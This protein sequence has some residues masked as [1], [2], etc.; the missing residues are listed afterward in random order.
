MSKYARL[1][2]M[3]VLIALALVL[4]LVEGM[5]P[6]PYVAPGVKIGLANLVSL[7]A[8]IYFGFKT[9]FLVVV[10]RILLAAFLSGRLYSIIYSGTGALLSI[11]IMGFVYWRFKKYFSLPGISIMGAVAHNIGQI[12]VAGF[13]IETGSV[14]AYLPILMI[15]GI[16]TGYFIGFSANLLRRV[17]DP[18]LLNKFIKPKY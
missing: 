12:L 2:Y 17:L 14:L 1:T 11:L 9:T 6:V 10:L 16:I 15:S 18:L 3:G 8:L 13:V 5:I 4:Q 7:I